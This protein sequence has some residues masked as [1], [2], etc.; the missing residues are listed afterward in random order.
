MGMGRRAFL[1]FA[2]KALGGLAVYPV[3]AIAVTSDYYVN[4][5]LGL[6]FTEPPRR[7][8]LSNCDCLRF[9]SRWVFQHEKITPTLIDDETLVI[10]QG[11]V[12]YTIHLYDTPYEGD[13][14]PDEF[15]QFVESLRL[16]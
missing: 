13:V 8:H 7:R 6:A 12:L 1:K 10:E 5:R 4:T 2:A 11:A 3:T 9:K 15:R 14:A 16:A